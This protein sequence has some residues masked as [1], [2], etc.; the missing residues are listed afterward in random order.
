[1]I[2]AMNTKIENLSAADLRRAADLSERIEEM[3]AELAQIL[4]GKK[5]PGRKPGAKKPGP[6]AGAKKKTAKRGGPSAAARKK[7]SEARRAYWAQK[8]KEKAKAAKKK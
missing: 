7:M 3:Q 8:R 2:A 6:K 1:M 5:K 4:S